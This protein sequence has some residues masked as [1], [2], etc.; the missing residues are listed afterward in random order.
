MIIYMKIV[1]LYNSM[2]TVGGV[3]RIL[4]DKIN[5]LTEQSGYDILLLTYEQGSR[6]SAFSLSS[7]VRHIDLGINFYEQYRYNIVKRLWVNE[8]K[9]RMFQK[10]MK[11]QLNLFKADIIICTSY[12]LRDIECVTPLKGKSKLIV[13]SHSAFESIGLRTKNKKGILYQ[14]ITTLLDKQFYRHISKSD[15][16]VV[17]TTEDISLWEPVKKAQVIPNC[18][19]EYPTHTDRSVEQNK[20]VIA[21]GRLTEQKGFDLLVKAW[22][23]VH[24][25]HTD[26]Q[27]NI[28]GKGEDEHLLIQEIEQRHLSQTIIL[29]EPTTEIYDRY[30]ESDFYVMSSRWEGF[31]LVLAEAM[32]CGVPC[33][34]FACPHGP[35]D[36]IRDNEDGLLVEKGNVRELA[37]KIC[38]LIENENIRIEMGRKARENIKRYLPENVMPQWTGLF[39]KLTGIK[40]E[41]SNII[42]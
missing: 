24:H 9:K 34:S 18:I 32:S 39:K 36:I 12:T 27:L 35:S 30:M 37:E 7:K 42:K 11:E 31:G 3:E 5:Y 16:L 14:L 26:W 22:E 17:L 20:K 29:H 2:D 40:D 41:D 25:T 19:T 38:Y 15:A 4:T 28:Y 10:R 8:V 33:V 13:E 23:I 21:V 6:P 1:Y